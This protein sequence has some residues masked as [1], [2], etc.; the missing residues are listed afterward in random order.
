[1]ISSSKNLSWCL[2]RQLKLN[3]E[4]ILTRC[5]GVSSKL[6]RE[7]I[8]IRYASSAASSSANINVMNV[9]DRSAKLLQRER[10]AN[11]REAFWFIVPNYV[12]AVFDL[13]LILN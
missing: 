10:A 3:K 2:R 12:N 9:F 4:G 6:N 8:L 5:G 1:M 11:V 13:C 7:G